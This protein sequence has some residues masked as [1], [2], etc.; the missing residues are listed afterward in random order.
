MKIS[1]KRVHQER[2]TRI[3]RKDKGEE[4]R[5]D[6]KEERMAPEDLGS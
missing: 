4:E 2:K 5:Q 6:E 1:T 3:K